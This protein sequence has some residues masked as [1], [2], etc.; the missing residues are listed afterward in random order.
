MAKKNNVSQLAAP[1]FAGLKQN[2]NT[3]RALM[4]FL[5]S[6]T[7]VQR[8]AALKIGDSR[9]AFIENAVHAAQNNPDVLPAVFDAQAFADKVAFLMQLEDF[10]RL[11]AQFNSDVSDTRLKSSSDVMAQ[12]LEVKQHIALAARRNP[13]LKAVSDLL[14]ESFKNAKNAKTHKPDAKA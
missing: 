10:Y 13:A 12:A 2:L 5:L 6:L 7:G 4:P 3:L 11:V 14:A 8:K 9:V 1:D